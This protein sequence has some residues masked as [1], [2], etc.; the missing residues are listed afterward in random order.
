MGFSVPFLQL[1]GLL[2]LAV[3]V[4]IVGAVAHPA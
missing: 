4:D 2:A 1:A 3:V